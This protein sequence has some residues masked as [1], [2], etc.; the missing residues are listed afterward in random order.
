MIL[1]RMFSGTLARMSVAVALSLL[2]HLSIF[3][4]FLLHSRSIGQKGASPLALTI[5]LHAAPAKGQKTGS[6]RQPAPKFPTMEVSAVPETRDTPS[7]SEKAPASAVTPASDTA[8]AAAS[9]YSRAEVSVPPLMQTEPV[10]DDALAISQEWPAQGR[11]VLRLF[12]DREGQVVDILETS[13]VD[14]DNPV[15][16]QLLAAFSSV[17]FSPARV[18]EAPVNSWI[19]IEIEPIAETPGSSYRAP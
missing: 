17:R 15:L 5:R 3:G 8:K 18:G 16:K 12:I 7:F 10:I 11:I 13:L 6:A 1:A 4:G 19:E 14:R 2:L 9:F